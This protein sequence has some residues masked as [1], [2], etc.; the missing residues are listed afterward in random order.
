MLTPPKKAND[1]KLQSTSP[2][3]YKG[4]NLGS[5]YSLILN[6]TPTASPYSVFNQSLGWMMGAFGYA[7]PAA[8]P[9]F[10]PAGGTYSSAQFVSLSDSSTGAIIYYTTDGATPT[11][12]S[13]IYT[14]PITVN[15][16]TTIKAL[17]VGSTLSASG[18]ASATYT[19]R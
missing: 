6:P 9:T 13:T 12:S 2:A 1:V 4:T 3:I 16:T 5:A 11:M 7:V 17:A 18:V 8:T 14:S 15:A 19:M 10:S